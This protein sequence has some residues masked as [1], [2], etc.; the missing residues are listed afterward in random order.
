[1]TLGRGSVEVTCWALEEFLKELFPEL[2]GIYTWTARWPGAGVIPDFAT[3]PV[4][5]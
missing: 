5:A 2:G 3:G 4:M 1:M